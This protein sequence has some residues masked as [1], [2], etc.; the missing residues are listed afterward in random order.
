MLA[1][2]GTDLRKWASEN[3]FI[4]WLNLCPNNKI[5]AGKVLSSKVKRKKSNAAAQ[6]FKHA[7]NSVQRS[8]HWLGDYFRRMKSKGGNKY[9]IV[10]TAAKIARIYYKMLTEKVAFKPMELSDYQS[11]YKQKQIAYLERKLEKL[12]IAAAA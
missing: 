7:A 5:S 8:D 10:A 4:G 9:A 11:E 3:R 2:T 12:K 6:S 1:E